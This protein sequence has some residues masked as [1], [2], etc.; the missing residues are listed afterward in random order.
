[1]HHVKDRRVNTSIF[2]VELEN[3]GKEHKLPQKHQTQVNSQKNTVHFIPLE[4]YN[5][6]YTVK[7]I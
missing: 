3:V 2:V 6:I 4:N 1:M 5:V 7:N